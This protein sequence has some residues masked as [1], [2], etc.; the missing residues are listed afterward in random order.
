[1]N[2]ERYI[3][4]GIGDGRYE[5]GGAG[6]HVERQLSKIEGCSLNRIGSMPFDFKAGTCETFNFDG[7]EMVLLCFDINEPTAC[8]T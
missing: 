8:R 1:M 4:G 3:F 2:N 6:A 7:V 5:D